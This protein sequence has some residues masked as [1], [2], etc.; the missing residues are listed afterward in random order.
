MT[1]APRAY[2]RA[3][4]DRGVFLLQRPRGGG[5]AIFPPRLAEPGSG[6]RDLI[7]FEPPRGGTIYSVTVIHP[8][9][10][11]APYH[12]ALIDLDAGVRVMGRVE[13]IDPASV[14]IGARV[15]GRVIVGAAGGLLVFDPA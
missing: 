11:A 10:P 15:A 9:P 8:R 7:W 4:L 14:A 5:A 1:A 12:V 3:A 2:W 6:D 13:G